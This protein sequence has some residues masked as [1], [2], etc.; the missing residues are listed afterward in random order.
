[1]NKTGMTDLQYEKSAK[2][3]SLSKKIAFSETGYYSYYKYKQKKKQGI[4]RK[5]KREKMTSKIFYKQNT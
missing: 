2:Y 4:E 1:M 5:A 3:K